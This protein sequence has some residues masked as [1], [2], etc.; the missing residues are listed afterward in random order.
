MLENTEGTIKNGQ[1]KETEKH[2]EHKTKT[3]KTKTQ[4][5]MCLTPL[6]ANKPEITK[7]CRYDMVNRYG[8]STSQ[9]TNNLFFVS[10]SSPNITLHQIFKMSNMIGATTW[11]VKNAYPTRAP[12]LIHGFVG[13][14]CWSV[15]VFVCS[16]DVF[17]YFWSLYCLHFLDL[18]LMTNPFVSLNDF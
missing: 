16:F 9:L 11:A 2:W 1:S 10:L 7:G 14:S 3:N 15:V 13:V 6:Y 12:E 8:I 4:H 18:R 17:V 5:N